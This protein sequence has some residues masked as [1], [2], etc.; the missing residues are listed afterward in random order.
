[1]NKIG[2]KKKNFFFVLINSFFFF[3]FFS[4]EWIT[5]IELIT[6]KTTPHLQQLSNNNIEMV[7]NDDADN[8]KNE[9][10]LMNEIFTRRPV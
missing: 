4:E 5:A 9:Y 1:M 8:T 10:P 3:Y 7:R 6:Q 2:I